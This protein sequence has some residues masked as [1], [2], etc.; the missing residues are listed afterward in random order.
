VISLDRTTFI[1][2]H[3]SHNMLRCCDDVISC[4]GYTDVAVIV[5]SGVVVKWMQDR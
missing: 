3:I 2:G 1:E 5:V 4:T